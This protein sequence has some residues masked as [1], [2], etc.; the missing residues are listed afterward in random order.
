MHLTD[1]TLREGDQIP[2]RE[3]TAEAKIECARALDDLGVPFVQPG[4]PATGEKD[5][6]VIGEL[7]GTTDADVV[8][9]ARALEG[10][11]DAALESDADVIETFV[12]ASDRHLEHLLGVSRGEML[13]MLGEAVDYVHDHGVTAH[14]TLADAFR[15]DRDHL[16]EIVETVPDVA[17]VSL[18]DTVG[19]RTPETVEECLDGLASH[20]AVDRLGVH[21]HDDMGCAT[22]NALA[23][24]R[25]GVGKADV[26]VGGLGERAGNT[27]LEE[28]AVA[29][30]VDHDDDLG[31]AADALV[32]TC[33]SVLDTLGE[34]YGDRKAVLGTAIAEHESGIH[35]AAMLSNPA[36]LEPFDP[37]RFGGERR[38]VFGK[39]TGE[40]GAR[41]L[42]E[43]AG[44]DPDSKT[45]AA[46][47]DA[48]AAAGPLDLD[49]ALALAKEEFGS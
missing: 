20:V 46:Y 36:T 37:G 9:L 28:L 2:G 34:P 8:A 33:R 14:V 29:C 18:A 26:S 47:L 41:R 22:A 15:T 39:P 38:L 43:R 4:F 10:D 13:S 32:P 24:Y 21:F 11:I 42:L 40:G 30:A 5:R 1:V 49:A 48:L 27:A 3:F 31:L 44:I 45:V 17:F 16:V 7:A 35:T 6:E 12:S 23:A 25:A 19:A